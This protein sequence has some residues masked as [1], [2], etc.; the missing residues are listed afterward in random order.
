MLP[1]RLSS[2]VVWIIVSSFIRFTKIGG[3][4]FVKSCL[5]GQNPINQDIVLF[6][7]TIPFYKIFIL[8]ITYYNY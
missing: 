6:Y 4:L 1:I 3:Y 5:T 8:F 7:R 2:S